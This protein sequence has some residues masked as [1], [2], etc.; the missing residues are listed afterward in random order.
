MSRDPLRQL[1]RKTLNETITSLGK[2]QITLES[3]D[4]VAY[5]CMRHL[6]EMNS[7][8]DSLVHLRNNTPRRTSRRYSYSRA[9]GSLR[10]EIRNIKR[11]LGN[12]ELHLD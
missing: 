2:R 9:I 4:E 1:I 12:Q 11:K 3:G 6:D 10:E 8:L 5:G 7:T